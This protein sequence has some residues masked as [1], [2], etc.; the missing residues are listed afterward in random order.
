MQRLFFQFN[1]FLCKSKQLYHTYDI[2]YHMHI[3]LELVEDGEEEMR[4]EM[5]EMADV[6]KSASEKEK[7]AVESL[8]TFKNLLAEKE[9]LVAA[10][11]SRHAELLDEVV[12]LN[13]SLQELREENSRKHAEVNKLQSKINI[14]V[15][16]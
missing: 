7:A 12:N 8:A 5:F 16:L 3:S 6:V 11:E 4:K 9:E 2:S 14:S 15:A 13:A 10:G 1:Q